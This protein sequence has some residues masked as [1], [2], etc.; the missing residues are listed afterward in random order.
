MTEILVQVR[1]DGARPFTAGMVVTDGRVTVAA[2]ILRRWVLGKTADE[3]LAVF[4][5]RGWRAVIV[6]A[7][8]PET[9]VGRCEKFVAINPIV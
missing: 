8:M 1:V 2:P 5:G 3:A 9:R 7:W 4:A 6:T